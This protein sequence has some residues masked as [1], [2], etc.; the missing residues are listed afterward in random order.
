MLVDVI[1]L[2]ADGVKLTEAALRAA[3]QLRGHLEVRTIRRRGIGM[4]GEQ[5]VETNAALRASPEDAP[6]GRAMAWMTDAKVVTLTSVE[7]LQLV[8]HGWEPVGSPSHERYQ[9]QAWWCTVV[10][11]G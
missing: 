11:G 8:I 3:T 10:V 9:P 5:L 6:T 1:L 7:P 4:P 2:R